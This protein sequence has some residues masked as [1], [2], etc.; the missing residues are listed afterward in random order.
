ME[1]KI[2][3]S[4]DHPFIVQLQGTFQTP[5]HIYMVFDFICGGELFS[6]LREET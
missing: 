6:L 5:S 2:L 1:K 4:I 3:E